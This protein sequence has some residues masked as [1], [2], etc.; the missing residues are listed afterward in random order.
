LIGYFEGINPERSI[1][2][3][4]ANSFGVH[5]FLGVGLE[6]ALPDHSTI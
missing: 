6:D 1:P 5:D 3:R 4:A 2:W